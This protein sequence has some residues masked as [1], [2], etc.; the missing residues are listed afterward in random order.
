MFIIAHLTSIKGVYAISSANDDYW[1]RPKF[2]EVNSPLILD[3]NKSNAALWHIKTKD[4]GYFSFHFLEKKID[5][6]Q[7]TGLVLDCYGSEK[8]NGTKV[9]LFPQGNNQPNQQFFCVPNCM[10]ISIPVVIE[11]IVS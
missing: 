7:E 5:K 3:K 10:G 4:G 8:N 2:P 11:S 1:I 6:F 9:I